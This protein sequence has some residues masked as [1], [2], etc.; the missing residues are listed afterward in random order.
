MFRPLLLFLLLTAVLGLGSCQSGPRAV[1]LGQDEC[2]HC[3]MTV[4][5]AEFAAQLVTGKGRQ[6]VFDDLLCLAS[7]LRENPEVAGPAPQLL[8]ADFSEPATWLPVEQAQLLRSTAFR[9]PMNGQLAA[10]ATA[11][12]A[13]AAE[14]KLSQPA[15]IISWNDVGQLQ[16][17]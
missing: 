14:G 10:F 9:S 15:K 13:Q 16:V 7:F 2:A 8:V 6:Y 1:R 5:K 12:A 11:A 4:V 3:R 17:H